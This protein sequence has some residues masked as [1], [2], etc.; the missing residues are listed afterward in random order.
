MGKIYYFIIISLFVSLQYAQETPTSLYC[1]TYKKEFTRDDADNKVAV[2]DVKVQKKINEIKGAF[3]NLEYKLFYNNT[4]SVFEYVNQLKKDNDKFAD[5]VIGIGG[6][7]G[8]YYSNSKS[9]EKINN[10]MFLGETFNI[11]IPY[12]QYDWKITNESKV[13]LEKKCFKAIGIYTEKSKIY[14]EKKTE[15]TAWFT[16]I[17]DVYFGPSGYDGLPGLV[18]EAQNNKIRFVATSIEENSTFVISRPKKGIKITLEE[19][20]NNIHQMIKKAREE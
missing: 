9:F 11:D 5:R 8:I 18:L 4:E 10:K 16:P 14:G 13:L 6:G 17:N 1:V 3:N 15:I 12:N 19:Y 20:T 2:K 7:D